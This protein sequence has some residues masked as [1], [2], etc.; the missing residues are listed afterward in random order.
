MFICQIVKIESLVRLIGVYQAAA[1]LRMPDTESKGDFL[2][3]H[4]TLAE[5]ERLVDARVKGSLFSGFAGAA[6]D[7]GM[8]YMLKLLTELDV[9]TSESNAIDD[10]E[11]LAE[12]RAKRHPV[13]GLDYIG[14]YGGRSILDNMIDS[15][16]KFI[17][18]GA[19]STSGSG[20]G[21]EPIAALERLA[22]VKMKINSQLMDSLLE[23]K[24]CEV[25]YRPR[26]KARPKHDLVGRG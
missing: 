5:L 17:N 18:N 26:A 25:V 21:V 14:S 19:F 15:K 23:A 6:L 3:F 12:L 1:L 9:N 4:E 24:I 7:N 22:E 16:I 20:D 10:L 8:I 11:R 13:N 2:M